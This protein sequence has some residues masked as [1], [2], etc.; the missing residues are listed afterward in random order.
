MAAIGLKIWS[1]P[2]QFFFLA[3]G[4]ENSF[5]GITYEEFISTG[6]ELAGDQGYLEWLQYLE[7]RYVV[8]N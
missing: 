3:P 8:K 6:R 4:H 5:K 2:G 7:D 1:M